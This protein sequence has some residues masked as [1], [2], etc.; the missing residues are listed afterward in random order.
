MPG[1]IHV[2]AV[3]RGQF[4]H[5][6]RPAFTIGQIG[7]FQPRK[8]HGDLLPGAFMR[9]ILD[10]RAH[11]LRVGNDIIGDRDGKVDKAR[12]TRQA[13]LHVTVRLGRPP[14]HPAQHPLPEKRAQYHATG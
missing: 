10:F 12:H 3:M 1:G 7:L 2:G 4:Q 13:S 6:D 9:H 5:L 8:E 14:H 11:H